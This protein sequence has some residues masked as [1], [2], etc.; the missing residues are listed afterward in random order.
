MLELV[1][2]QAEE[3]PKAAGADDEVIYSASEMIATERKNQEASGRCIEKLQASIPIG[4][5]KY[6]HLEKLIWDM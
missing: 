1:R 3:L 4:A 2:R 5:R 6:I